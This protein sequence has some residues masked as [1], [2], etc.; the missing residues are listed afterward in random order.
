[1]AHDEG[2]EREEHEKKHAAKV[3]RKLEFGRTARISIEQAIQT[4]KQQ[5]SG[6]VIE[7]ELEEE[8]GKRV[9]EVEIM[10]ADDRIRKV[11]VDSE[12]GGIVEPAG[13]ETGSRSR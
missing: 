12:T 13:D 5:V 10:T 1:M 2:Q 3:K 4:A 9:W 11:Y 7:A 6:K 8:H